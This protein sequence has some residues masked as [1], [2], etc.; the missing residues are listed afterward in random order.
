MIAH[1]G[2]SRCRVQNEKKVLAGIRTDPSTS[3]RHVAYETD[4]SQECCLMYTL[5]RNC[6][7]LFMYNLYKD[8]N[9]QIIVFTSSYVIGFYM[10]L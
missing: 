1:V 5:D 4:L 7:Y 3:A 10:E 9:Q 8:C 2:C 6:F